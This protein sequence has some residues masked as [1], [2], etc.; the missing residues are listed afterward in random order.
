L[1]FYFVPDRI[2]TGLTGDEEP[3][4][5]ER[6]IAKL[7]SDVLAQ[8]EQSESIAVKSAA[9]RMRMQWGLEAV[10]KLILF[11]PGSGS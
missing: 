11:D 8:L 6:V 4:T 10:G 2:H 3:S 9:R 7:V 5:E 1:R